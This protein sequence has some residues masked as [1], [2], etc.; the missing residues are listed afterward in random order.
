MALLEATLGAKSSSTN[1]MVRDL[2]LG[3]SLA[4]TRDSSEV[5]STANL[6]FSSGLRPTAKEGTQA[7]KDQL[8]QFQEVLT[9][10]GNEARI[11]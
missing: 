11:T 9:M 8:M 10:L 4:T 1:N 7:Y 5:A 6:L 3:S 2:V